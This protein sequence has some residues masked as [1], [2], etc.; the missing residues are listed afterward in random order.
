[1]QDII[2]QSTSPCKS[3]LTA[4][5]NELFN[6]PCY[7]PFPKPVIHPEQ[8]VPFGTAYPELLPQG[9][10]QPAALTLQSVML[11]AEIMTLSQAGGP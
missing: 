10:P 11:P 8:P 4:S 9:L 3:R 6:P 5:K 1:M 2:L 7:L